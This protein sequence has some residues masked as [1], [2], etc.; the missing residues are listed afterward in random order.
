MQKLKI[1]IFKDADEAIRAGYVYKAPMKGVKV[2]EAV[3]IKNGTT[4]GNPTVD[5]IFEDNEGNRY[6]AMTTG[7]LLKALLL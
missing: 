1:K 2:T 5:I 3:I 4:T 6:V 7:A